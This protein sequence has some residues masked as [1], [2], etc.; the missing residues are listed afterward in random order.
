MNA[1]SLRSARTQSNKSLYD[2][3]SKDFLV[4]IAVT[5]DFDCNAAVP[6]SFFKNKM[7]IT[8]TAISKIIKILSDERY[9]TLKLDDSKGKENELLVFIT[10]IGL[11][12]IKSL[13]MRSIS[14]D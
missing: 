2:K 7:G 10:D 11:E 13:N 1:S 3:L 6:L 5:A 8:Y 9:V 12:K 4:L 14:F